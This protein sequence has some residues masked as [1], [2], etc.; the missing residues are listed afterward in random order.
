MGLNDS[1]VRNADSGR[2]TTWILEMALN[3]GV[4]SVYRSLNNSVMILVLQGTHWHWATPPPPVILVQEVLIFEGSLVLFILLFDKLVNACHL[5]C[6]VGPMFV[7]FVV[8]P[9]CL[10][11]TLFSAWFAD[12]S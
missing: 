2:T 12:Y 7:P 10:E 1:K 9:C 5:M 6:I 11:A 8:A 3:N 4:P